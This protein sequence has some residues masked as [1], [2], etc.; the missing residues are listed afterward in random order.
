MQDMLLEPRGS[1]HIKYYSLDR[2]PMN[3]LG[4]HAAVMLEDKGWRSTHGG[5]VGGNKLHQ[6]R[7]TPKQ[8]AGC[9]WLLMMNFKAGLDEL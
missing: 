8:S 2:Y 3:L 1:S 9:S 7:N 5:G 6:G 4:A